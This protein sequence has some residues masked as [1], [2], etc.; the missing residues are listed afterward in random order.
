MSPLSA[1]C[2]AESVSCAATVLDQKSDKAMARLLAP[3]FNISLSPLLPD[4]YLGSFI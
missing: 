1:S 2:A 4:C 3:N